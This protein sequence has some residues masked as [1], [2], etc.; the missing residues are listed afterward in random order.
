MSRE[1][2]PGAYDDLITAALAR[3]V[4]AGR[5]INTIHDEPIEEAEAHSYVI[6]HL[7]SIAARLLGAIRD[8]DKAGK[9]GTANLLAKK[10]LAEVQRAEDLFD[11]GES[12]IALSLR[13]PGRKPLKRGFVGL[14]VAEA[15]SALMTTCG[16]PP[17]QAAP[18]WLRRRSPPGTEVD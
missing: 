10:L 17:A 3:L 1:L 2:V 7:T 16:D 11:E 14:V 18:R 12:E 5:A 4:E 8:E 9:A 15:S 13:R 6:R